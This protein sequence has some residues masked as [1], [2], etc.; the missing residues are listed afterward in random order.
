VETGIFST[1]L[2]YDLAREFMG[3][4]GRERLAVLSRRPEILKSILA[5]IIGR[6]IRVKLEGEA[7][8]REIDEVA[9]QLYKSSNVIVRYQS[10]GGKV[11]TFGIQGVIST[12]LA[13][14]SAVGGRE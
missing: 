10:E 7:R 12:I 2:C 3:G 8:K 13:Y 1:S 5:N 6:N 4:E 9:T 11:E 14:N